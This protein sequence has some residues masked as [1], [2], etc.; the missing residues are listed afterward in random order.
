MSG[1]EI[2]HEERL[3]DNIVGLVQLCRDI[4]ADANAMGYHSIDPTMLDVG[5]KILSKLDKKDIINRFISTSS[6]YWEQIRLKDEDFFKRNM[7]SIFEGLP[8]GHINSISKLFSAVDSTTGQ[9][10]IGEE[11]REGVWEFL[12]SMVKICIKYIHQN[13]QPILYN[14]DGNLKPFYKSEFYMEV[15]LEKHASR[16]NVKLQFS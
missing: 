6:P 16:Y 4:V 9:P 12:I 3:S 1:N 15:P 14:V 8:A 2:S 13:R 5:A 11:D 10:I 7:S